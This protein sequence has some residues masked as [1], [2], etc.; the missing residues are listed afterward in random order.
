MLALSLAG[1]FFTDPI[2]DPETDPD[3][4]PET[5]PVP[6]EVSKLGTGGSTGSTT[7]KL[8]SLGVTAQIFLASW[9]DILAKE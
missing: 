3:P 4:D 7:P 5:D 8:T 2:P 6:D 9:L 1:D